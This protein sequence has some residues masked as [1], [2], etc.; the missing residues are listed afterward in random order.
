MNDDGE[1]LVEDGGG[2]N[3]PPAAP[4]PAADDAAA[5]ERG[6]APPRA[7]APPQQYDGEAQAATVFADRYFYMTQL[8]ADNHEGARAAKLGEMNV[9]QVL[10]NF[11]T[12]DDEDVD[13]PDFMGSTSGSVHPLKALAV[14]IGAKPASVRSYYNTAD[15]ETKTYFAGIF[16]KARYKGEFN[17]CRVELGKA[18]DVLKNA[19]TPTAAAA[20]LN[21]T[22][23][24]TNEV[25]GQGGGSNAP[26]VNM[27]FLNGLRLAGKEERFLIPTAVYVRDCMKVI[28][29]LFLE[30]V[31]F[32]KKA[33]TKNTALIG[34][35]GVGKSILFFLA[36]LYQAQ[37]RRVVYYRSTKTE[38]EGASLFFMRPAPGDGSSVR[39][40]FSRNMDKRFIEGNGGITRVSL[41]VERELDM[42]RKDYYA[43]IDGPNHTDK[44]DLMVG[45]YD[46][47]C[48]SGGFPLYSSTED[49]KRLWILDGW[50]REEA[51]AGLAAIAGR[52]KSKAEKIYQLCGGKIRDMLKACNSPQKVSGDINRRVANLTFDAMSMALLSTER[53]TDP[54]SPDRLRTM[55]L[56]KSM[57]QQDGEQPG[58]SAFGWNDDLFAF[59]PELETGGEEPQGGADGNDVM[60]AYQVVDSDYALN[61]L[62]KTMSVQSFVKSYK[63]CLELG[64]R[65]GAGNFFERII[66][67][68]VA[69]LQKEGKPPLKDV[70]WSSG[71]SK[72]SL[73]QLNKTGVYWIPS[74]S[75]FASIDSALVHD[76]TLYLFQMT[77]A[78]RHDFNVVSFRRAFADRVMN[79]FRENGDKINESKMVLFVVVPRGSGF[80]IDKSLEF[81]NGK[82]WVKKPKEIE[83]LLHPVDLTGPDKVFESIGELMDK[84]LRGPSRKSIVVAAE[85][86]SEGEGQR[87]SWFRRS[88]LR[89]RHTEE[90][91]SKKKTKTQGAK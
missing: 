69:D 15:I 78:D 32:S 49:G 29:G 68:T 44:F 50:T 79:T 83:S 31:A 61:M 80:N 65:S 53:S 9:R 2:R 43:Y 23:T 27:E 11:Y 18:L 75:N 26:T 10:E 37:E 20:A 39:V 41:D 62:T 6:G 52:D 8:D 28:F 33:G 45:T 46:Y 3:A 87:Q 60:N 13:N 84:I 89:L 17:E 91:T 86:G 12:S 34:S 14:A 82:E 35:P 25:Q 74:V 67:R 36:A 81:T 59:K 38:N 76:H 90:P 63:F 88:G 5:S 42:R 16:L 64:M 56:N 70:C 1:G 24:T 66:H 30:D 55:F 21:T 72:E 51:I 73:K 48:T 54:S 58:D 71:N 7:R 4:A 22:G 77:I 47:F 40:W 19:P 57:L 85:A